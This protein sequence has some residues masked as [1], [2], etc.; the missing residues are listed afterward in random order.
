MLSCRYS[1]PDTTQYNRRLASAD[2][3]LQILS[4][5][6]YVDLP[7]LPLVPYAM[8][9]ATTTIYRAL[10]DGQRDLESS[11]QELGKCCQTLDDLSKEWTTARGIAKLTRRLWK[12]VNKTW[13]DENLNR[14]A[15][16]TSPHETRGPVAA[17]RA[18]PLTRER[19]QGPPFQSISIQPNMVTTGSEAS[20]SLEMMQ[21][22]VNP[23]FHL[24]DAYLDL[25]DYGMP[26]VFRDPAT[27]EF[28]HTSPDDNW[29]TQR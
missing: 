19:G 14:R 1:G 15:A 9:M 21:G 23:L 4:D 8:S 11:Q 16:I 12:I 29:G 22:L 5:G 7:P 10:C 24:N 2:R 27:W 18:T 17:D 6:A 20:G 13:E 26:N 3:I 28:L 25:F